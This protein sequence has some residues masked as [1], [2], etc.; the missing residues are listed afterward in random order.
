MRLP[1]LIRSRIDQWIELY[2]S[3]VHG[4]EDESA[5]HSAGKW[6]K[7]GYATGIYDQLD[8][9]GYAAYIRSKIGSEI[10]G[11]DRKHLQ[12]SHEDY[13][14]G[15]TTALMQVKNSLPRMYANGR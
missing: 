9:Y 1:G 15:Y 4:L 5:S 7:L 3:N 8:E 11:H 13:R 2:I 14:K 10:A 12:A 6:Y